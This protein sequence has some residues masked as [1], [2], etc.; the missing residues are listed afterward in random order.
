M[1]KQNDY[2][3]EL[4]KPHPFSIYPAGC[5]WH[6]LSTGKNI[7]IGEDP[8]HGLYPNLTLEEHKEVIDLI[9]NYIEQYKNNFKDPDLYNKDVVSSVRSIIEQH[10]K[11][12][13]ELIK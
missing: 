4:G 8:Y 1:K 9:V 2:P 11:K 3:Y 7:D 10:E 13:I 5:C 6:K 12:I